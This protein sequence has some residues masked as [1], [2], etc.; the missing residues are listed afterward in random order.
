[1][2]FGKWLKEYEKEI[3]PEFNKRLIK[4]VIVPQNLDSELLHHYMTY[5]INKSNQEL[6]GITQ[7]LAIATIFLG[8]VSAIINLLPIILK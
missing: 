5:R 7:I 1:M 2:S 8:L 3:K 6:V 4:G